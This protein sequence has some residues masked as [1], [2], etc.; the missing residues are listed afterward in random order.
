MAS[1][2]HSNPSLTAVQPPAQPSPTV[3]VG[4]GGKLCR[5]GRHNDQAAKFCANCGTPFQH[6]QLTEQLLPQVQ[7]DLP[8]YLREMRPG[9]PR[10]QRSYHRWLVVGIV[11]LVLLGGPGALLLA[12]HKSTSVSPLQ[13]TQQ[14]AI[15]TMPPTPTLTFTPLKLAGAAILGGNISAFIAKYGPPFSDAGGYYV[16]ANDGVDVTASGLH[17]FAIAVSAPGN[18]TWSV[19]QAESI[20]LALVPPDRVYERSRIILDPLEKPMAL[21]KVYYS[22]VLSKQFPA[23]DFTDENANQLTPG[24]LGLVLTY[25]GG[26]TSKILQCAVE[27]G[28]Q[29]KYAS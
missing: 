21:Q 2:Q 16:F 27:V 12:T 14:S 8:S 13:V 22:A 10:Q 1:L 29:P 26:N 5:C 3:E 25:D 17:A 19:K 28:L 9:Q 15:P 7:Q 24:T 20:C 23:S 6:Q 11:A 4:G 18:T